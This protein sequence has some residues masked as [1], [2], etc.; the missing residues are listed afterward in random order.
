MKFFKYSTFIILFILGYFLTGF[1]FAQELTTTSFSLNQI[2]IT[3]PT[4]GQIIV[5]T[6]LTITG[7]APAG[8]LVTVTI[9]DE[10]YQR[11]FQIHQ[12]NLIENGTTTSDR[13]GDWVFVPSS[14][15]VPGKFSVV[16]AYQSSLTG[17][18]ISTEK[19]FFTVADGAG[20]TS[21]FT[22]PGFTL[23]IIIFIL[24]AFL[25][26]IIFKLLS[27]KKRKIYIKTSLGDIP[28]KEVIDEN[29]NIDIVP[30][31]DAVI[32]LGSPVIPAQQINY[33]YQPA[34]MLPNQIQPIQP[35]Y[36]QQPINPIYNP[37][38]NQQINSQVNPSLQSIPSQQNSNVVQ[39]SNIANSNQNSLPNQPNKVNPST[40]NNNG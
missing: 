28:A 37:Q 16:A 4:Q 17:G 40:V 27:R 29:D 6:S 23:I 9:Q 36:I 33:G 21:W 7:K 8:S 3:R 39:N 35:T 13:N 18:S 34:V 22:I 38:L 14:I 31:A 30:I 19:I 11:P 12:E 5:S 20:S 24:I 1:I 32:N 26:I 25:L 10:D 2:D 15:L